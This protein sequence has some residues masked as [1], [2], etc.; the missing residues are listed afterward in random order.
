MKRAIKT[1]FS[2]DL[3]TAASASH[4]QEG[5]DHRSARSM[6]GRQGVWHN[7]EGHARPVG[8]GGATAHP[9]IQVANPRGR[10]PAAKPNSAQR[11][12]RSMRPSGHTGI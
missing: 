7:P 10:V 8:M 11:P 4:P 2:D 6:S 5:R 1:G 12:A 3:H 9:K